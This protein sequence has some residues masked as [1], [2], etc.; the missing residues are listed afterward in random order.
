MRAMHSW[1]LVDFGCSARVGEPA[2]HAM[3]SQTCV[4]RI[5]MLLLP[6]QFLAP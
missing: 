4:T 5:E 3:R 2:A 1:T 6:M